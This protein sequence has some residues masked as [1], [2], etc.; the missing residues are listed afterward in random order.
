[1]AIKRVRKLINLSKLLPSN[2]QVKTNYKL[3][4]FQDFYS[5]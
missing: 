3:I 1:M 2:R 5:R 4:I